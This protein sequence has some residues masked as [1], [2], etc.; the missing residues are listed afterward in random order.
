M[1]HQNSGKRVLLQTDPIVVAEVIH[2]FSKL[3]RPFIFDWDSNARTSCVHLSLSAVARLDFFSVVG[4]EFQ[5]T[6]D[7]G[8]HNSPRNMCAGVVILSIC[9]EKQ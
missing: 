5:L 1:D 2:R 6:S 9:T 3:R 4:A 8:D 7:I